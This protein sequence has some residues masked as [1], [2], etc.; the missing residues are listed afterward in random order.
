MSKNVL[1]PI[2]NGSE[3]I[4]TV[5]VIDILR[6]AG[7][8]V[9]IAGEHEII[10]CSKGVKIIPDLLIS[11]IDLNDEYDAVIIPGGSKGTDNLIKNEKLIEILKKQNKNNKLI[12]AIC[13]A[14][15]ILSAHN[16]LK[17]GQKVTSHPSVKDS[18]ITY[19]YQEQRVIYD[20]DIITS[21]G[22]GTA[23]EFALYLVDILAGPE[24]AVKIAQDIVFD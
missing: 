14:P 9:K 15:S 2:A 20:Y 17:P 23:V 6:R 24:S 18:L 22:A 19:N 7:I 8:N 1:V 3:E 21:R 11:N 4:E 12:G 10:T 13:A 16:I 5:V